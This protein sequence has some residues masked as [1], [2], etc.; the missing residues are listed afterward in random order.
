MKRRENT[1]EE[2]MDKNFPKMMKDRNS[3]IQ[4]TN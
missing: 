1:F 2:I 3:Q 4:D